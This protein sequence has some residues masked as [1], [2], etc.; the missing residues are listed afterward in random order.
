MI[1]CAAPARLEWCLNARHAKQQLIV[2]FRQFASSSI[3]VLEGR[4]LHAPQPR[5]PRTETAVIAFHLVLVLPALAV[6]ANHADTLR[7]L[8]IIC[9]HGSSLS[10]GPEVLSR[11]KT[12]SRCLAHRSGSLPCVLTSR[13]I[14]AAVGLARIFKNH[15]VVF[16]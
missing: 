4:Q 1:D 10:P 11:G 7:Q 14:F 5:L 8:F 6:I 3:P 9:C 2:G 13:K 12:E 16:F 15:H